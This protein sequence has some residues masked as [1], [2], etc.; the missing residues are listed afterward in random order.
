MNSNLN[1][2]N[3]WTVMFIAHFKQFFFIAQKALQKRRYILKNTANKK[4]LCEYAV[5]NF[6]LARDVDFILIN[7]QLNEIYNDIDYQLKKNFIWFSVE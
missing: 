7:N 1:F 5:K 6:K 4:K 3:V 2:I